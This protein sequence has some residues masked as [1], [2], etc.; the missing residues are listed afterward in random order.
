[1]PL[2]GLGLITLLVQF[3]CAAHVV[4]TDR[5][6]LWIVPIIFLP[7]FGCAAYLIA[8]VL[9]DAL[10]GGR[11]HRIADS[12]ATITDPGTSYSRKKRD[13]ETIGSAQSKRVF[14]EE[15]IRRGRYDEAVA[16][17]ASAMDGAHME[18]PALLH[19]LARAKLLAGDGPGSQ[20]AFE[21]LKAVS[22]ADFTVDARLDYA[23]ALTLQHKSE[24][25]S[26]EFEALLPVYPGQEARCRYA[27][28]LA[29]IGRDER[30]QQLF[31]EIVDSQKHAPSYSRAREREWRKIAERNLRR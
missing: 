26:R 4:R 14:A 1:M 31:R 5:S 30:A 21:S 18:D 12:A 29:E 10:R 13:V 27:L 8:S 6:Y 25:A 24:E 16:L 3:A 23:R 28:L 17:Y 20:A 19:G 7:W 15:C 11:M 9:P 2:Y 22:P